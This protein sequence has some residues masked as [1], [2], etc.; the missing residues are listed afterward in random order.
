MEPYRARPP[1]LV[2]RRRRFS[3]QAGDRRFR[4]QLRPFV[5][6]CAMILLR[7]RRPGRRARRH[8]GERAKVV[9]LSVTEGD[10]KPLNYPHM[11]KAAEMMIANKMGLLPYVDFDPERALANALQVNPSRR[12]AFPP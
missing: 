11:F 2:L 8:R 6:Y 10:D 1:V 7:G 12:S 3:G 5:G 9:I 4:Q